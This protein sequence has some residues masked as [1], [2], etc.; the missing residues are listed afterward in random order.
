MIDSATVLIVVDVQNDFCE[1]GALAVPGGNN[2][3]DSINALSRRFD[4]VVM[5]QDWHPEA[6]LSFASSHVGAKP[7]DVIQMPYG[8]QVLWPD[9]CVMGT[10]GAGFH[11]ALDVARAQAIIRKGF[12]RGVDSYSGFMEAD[13]RTPTGLGGYLTERKITRVAL[14][15]IATDFCVYWTAMDARA[16]GLETVVIMDACRAIDMNGSL[17]GAK[18]AMLAVGVRHFR[19]ADVLP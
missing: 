9:H 3:V 18:K 17:Q 2:V 4:H 6:H 16:A 14:A 10:R 15:G 7:F 19:M 12:R 5:T 1:G 13:R 11:P 8:P